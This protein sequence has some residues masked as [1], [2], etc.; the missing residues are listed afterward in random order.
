MRFDPDAWLLTRPRLANL[1]TVLISPSK[2]P[3][4]SLVVLCHGF[5][6]SGTDLVGV[7]EE[8]LPHLPEDSPKSAFLFPEAPIDM[9]DEGMYGSRAWWR[10][11][12]AALMLMSE[13]NS[14]HQ[15][16]D[17]V[18]DGIDEARTA[19]CDCVSA[20]IQTQSWEGLRIVLGGF[21]QG[22]MLTVDTALRGSIGPIAGLIVLS[23]A[24]ICESQWRT[25]ASER[26]LAVPLVQ[27]HG[28]V[29]PI[30]PIETG[31]WLHSL[32][33]DIGCKGSLLEFNG[34]HTIPADACQRIASLISNV[35]IT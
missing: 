14:F 28:R 18:P 23:G 13:T 30:L 8:L 10:L 32:L 3:P 35:A 25:A 26:P 34:P 7:F 12:M 9:S 16:R 15:M 11:N 2:Q 19:L 31:R 21:S 1:N 20:C 22:A 33:T 5:G 27:S 24:L 17:A 29:D 4:A 6:A